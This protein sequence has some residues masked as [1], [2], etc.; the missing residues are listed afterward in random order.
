M[1]QI[2]PNDIVLWLGSHGLRIVIISALAF[3]LQ[4]IV[5]RGVPQLFHHALVEAVEEETLRE[6]ARKRSDTLSHFAV[7][8]SGITLLVLAIFM[9]LSELELDITPVLAGAGIAGIAVG[10]GAQT[11]VRDIISGLL[12]LM[13]NQYTKGDVVN[14]AG[15]GG[16]VEHVGLRRTVLRDLDGTVHS[17][18]NGEIR[19]ASNLTRGWSRV[20][21]NVTVGY[22]EDLDRVIAV[23]NE[24][25]E[26][27]AQD[28]EF[29]PLIISPPKVL[30]VEA[31]EESGIALK[32]LGETKPI[33]QWE[34]MGE[35][36]KRIKKAFDKAHIEI[37]FPH[38]VIIPRSKDTSPPDS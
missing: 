9:I 8:A 38:R 16:L 27:L 4:W 15:I 22:G 13:E 12:I 14:V 35:L 1:A 37:P 31:F 34:V 23:V 21:M 25:G 3:L 18:P 6:E 24:V 11:V 5:R 19:I 30:R 29:G 32:I 17:I 10:F 7:R 36:R 20:N 2:D 33:R 28:V 26:E